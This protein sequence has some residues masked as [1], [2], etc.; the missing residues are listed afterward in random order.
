MHHH[1]ASSRRHDLFACTQRRAW[2]SKAGQTCA[3]LGIEPLK[4]YGLGHCVVSEV[5]PYSDY[6]RFGVERGL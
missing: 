5:I 6:A 3:R 1:N 4:S 2:F